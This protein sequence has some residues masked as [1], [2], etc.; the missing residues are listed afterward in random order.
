MDKNVIVCGDVLDTLSELP[1]GCVHCVVTSPP[2]WGLRDYSVEG[3]LGL[4]K[5]PREYIDKMTEVFRE[6]KRVLREDGTLWLNM[7]DSYC[8]SWGNSGRRPEL[9]EGAGGQRP[10]SAE[11]FSRGGWDERRERPPGSYKIPGLKPKDLCGIPWQLAFALR[12]DGW[13]LRCDIIWAKPNPMPESC[14]DRPTKAH[15]YL[16]LLTKSPRYFYDAEAIREVTGHEA[17]PSEYA[18]SDGRV[19]FHEADLQAGMSQRN[20]AYRSMTHPSGRNRRSVW[21]I[22]TAPYPEAHFA[23]FPPKLVEPCIKAGTSEKGCCPECGK[24]WERV[25]ER[26]PNP[27]KEANVGRDLTGG[28]PNMGG[29]RQTSKGL[30]RNDGNAQGLAPCTIGWQPGCECLEKRLKDSE[31]AYSPYIPTPC[32]VLD[33]FMGSGTVGMVAAQLGRNYIGIELNP[34]YC[35]MAEHRIAEALNPTTYSRADTPVDAPLFEGA[36]DGPSPH[37]E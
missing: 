28:A 6:V 4:E 36:K 16:F 32:L 23:T 5:T 25:V 15:E 8:G 13:Y 7:G 22:P 11:Y 34:D 12:D 29:N 30:H 24:P 14:T 10:K 17:D 31:N 37:M 27:S 9:D 26:T 2:Y 35:Q 3:Q 19:H 21:T 33:P 1:D 20:P 18:A